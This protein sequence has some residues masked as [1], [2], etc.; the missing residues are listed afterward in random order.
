MQKNS[1]YSIIQ[2][3]TIINYL[4]SNRKEAVAVNLFFQLFGKKCKKVFPTL[5]KSVSKVGKS[6]SKV[7]KK[8]GLTPLVKPVH[9]KLTGVVKVPGG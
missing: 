9:S 7:G 1:Y 4:P 3:N 5:E 6:V 8:S 2:K